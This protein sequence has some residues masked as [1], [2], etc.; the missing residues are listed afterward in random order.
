MEVGTLILFSGKMGAGK[1]TQSKR[2]SSERNAVRISEDEWLSTLYPNQIST[3]DNYLHYS[4]LLKPLVRSHVLDIL[5]TGTS[6]VMDFPANTVKQRKWFKEL[7][8]EANSPNELIYL[9]MSN[10]I[11]LRQLAKRRIEQPERAV[12]DT[13]EIFNNVTSYF[14]PPDYSEGFN[15][16][17]VERSE[18]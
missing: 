10:D 13:E 2:V 16:R 1:S 9:N 7:I 15:L 8:A 12:F 5:R 17:I 4:A 14:Q 3:F 11:C 6:V 18:S